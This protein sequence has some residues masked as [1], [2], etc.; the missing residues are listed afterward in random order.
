MLWQ[1]LNNE[2]SRWHKTDAVI[3]GWLKERQQLLQQFMAATRLPS[4]QGK[5]VSP[6]IAVVERETF[7]A[8]SNTLV[9]YVSTLHF[10]ILEQLS[11]LET[12]LQAQ[13][14]KG[15]SIPLGLNRALLEKILSTTNTILEFELKCQSTLKSNAPLD[16]LKEALS[17]LGETLAQRMDLEDALIHSYVWARTALPNL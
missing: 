7:I 17:A 11:L 16:T 14:K 4:L 15:P 13:L 2:K 3:D 5:K 6:A 8:L 1:R 12:Q 9:D 10:E